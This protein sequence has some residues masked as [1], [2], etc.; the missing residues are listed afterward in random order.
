M[1]K[2]ETYNN[3]SPIIFV[4]K[5]GYTI[6]VISSFNSV[7]NESIE[8]ILL[9]EKELKQRKENLLDALHAEISAQKGEN[10]KLLNLKRT[11]YN[12]K[13][14][15]KYLTLDL[16]NKQV[17]CLLKGFYNSQTESD[18]EIEI[19]FRRIENS[20][21]IALKSLDLIT[22]KHFFKNGL[23]H[24]SHVLYDQIQK[25]NFEFT[26]LNKK[27]KKLIVSILKY[28]TRSV[29]KTTPFS[30]FNTVFY[31]EKQNEGFV[32]KETNAQS[33]IQI[34]NLLFYVLK[35][36][37]LKNITFK[38][39]LKLTFNKNSWLEKNEELH[40]FVNVNNNEALKKIH[41]SPFLKFLEDES[42][43]KELSYNDMVTLIQEKL[44]ETKEKIH[45]Y[46]SILIT[47]GILKLIFPVLQHQVNWISK[48]KEFIQSLNCESLKNSM[49]FL[50][51]IENSI[52]ELENI[53]I[54]SDDKK[55]LIQSGIR[56]IN[57]TFISDTLLKNIKAQDLYYEDVF[58]S[59]QEIIPVVNYEKISNS[60]KEAFFG[61]NLLSGKR[62]VKKKLKRL[63]ISNHEEKMPLLTFY[64][65][66]YLKFKND[67]SIEEEETRE[68][69][70]LINKIIKAKNDTNEIDL[71]PFVN[72]PNKRIATENTYS[73][74]GAYIQTCDSKF[75]KIVLNSFSKGRFANSSRFL[76]NCPKPL[77]D[78]IKMMNNHDNYIIADV[79]DASIHNTN[80]HP[81]L[82]NH[83]I[84]L[85]N[86]KKLED[87]Y[88]VIQ[89]NDLYV[90]T[91]KNDGIILVNTKGKKILPT[92]FS[93]ESLYR[94]SKFS[95]FLDIFDPYDN[96]GYNY[97]IESVNNYFLD[98]LNKNGIVEVP[99][100]VFGS[101]L[102]L[103]RKKWYI[104]KNILHEIIE[105][106]N[107]SLGK[108]FY[109]MNKWRIQNNIPEEVFLK[110]KKNSFTD[111]NG[112]KYKPQ[113]I[114]FKTPMFCF[115]LQK[116]IKEADDIIIISEMLP[117]TNN[118]KENGGFVKE[119]VLNIN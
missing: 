4:R 74:F 119:Y 22:K 16:A 25:T 18:K 108:L 38:N 76:T 102:V 90:S 58:E 39:S 80:I 54:S 110:I 37:L 35:T 20:S 116:V 10:K 75:S 49:E 64:K 9:V 77:I 47:E 84:S 95:Q 14:L 68:S 30:S 97:I 91:D 96:Y 60:L 92:Q 31:L 8:R 61:L 106:N 101:E 103:E 48:L 50:L 94:K 55:S 104:R 53:S 78:E 89:L 15:D 83:V 93:M 12:D 34:N 71:K 105:K 72:V 88:E 45:L 26:S 79:K 86:Q 29:T 41:Y 62:I 114:N 46:L 1:I 81:P 43:N 118:V 7:T 109:E 21:M 5:G 67:A 107:E 23:L 59:S 33:F 87:E 13:N 111:K 36:E 57:D 65:D 11:I 100:L 19:F 115:L 63:L 73:V 32:A 6:Q 52:S 3:I 24:S 99:R 98:I 113:Y 56:K 70:E 40:F 44:S 2:K 28:L 69:W 112:N 17:E 66:F 51:F 85:C 42:F 117:S 82:S 27:S